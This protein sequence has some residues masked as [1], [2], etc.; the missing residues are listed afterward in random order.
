M[1]FECMYSR[2]NVA[3]ELSRHLNLP[4]RIETYTSDAIFLDF[5]VDE[6]KYLGSV[7]D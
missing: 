3:R 7:S 1:R 6:V 2:L 5:L 4:S